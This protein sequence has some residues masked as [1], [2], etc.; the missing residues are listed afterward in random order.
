MFLFKAVV[1]VVMWKRTPAYCFKYTI[2]RSLIR[3]S[4]PKENI[5]CDIFTVSNNTMFFY[6]GGRRTSW[7]QRRIHVCSLKRYWYCSGTFSSR[8]YRGRSICPTD[9]ERFCRIR[10]RSCYQVSLRRISSWTHHVAKK[11]VSPVYSMFS[12]KNCLVYLEKLFFLYCY[13]IRPDVTVGIK[14]SW[15]NRS[16]AIRH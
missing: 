16:L 15:V 3:V 7:G 1:S 14:A 5:D 4:K 12:K 11:L 6:I 9:E 13:W 2:Q 10:H 8:Q